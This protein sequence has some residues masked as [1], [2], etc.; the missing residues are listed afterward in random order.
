QKLHLIQENGKVTWTINVQKPG[1][2]YL[3]LNYKGKG[4]LVWKAVTDEGVKVQNQQ[5]ATEKYIFYNMGIIEFKT[6]GN[7]TVA[8]SLVE[9]DAVSSSLRAMKLKPIN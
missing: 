5:A 4:R 1:Y 8:V 9:G 7:H 2:Y 6:A 3:D